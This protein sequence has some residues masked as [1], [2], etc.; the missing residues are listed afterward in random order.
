[1]KFFLPTDLNQYP[2]I[3]ETIIMLTFRNTDVWNINNVNKTY[4]NGISGHQNVFDE[5]ESEKTTMI[6]G[7]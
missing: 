6:V 2:S 3:I 7:E 5:E 4:L 1:M